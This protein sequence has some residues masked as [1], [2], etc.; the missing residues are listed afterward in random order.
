MIQFLLAV[1]QLLN[2]LIYAKGEGFGMADESI[3]AR[4]WRLRYTGRNWLY[5][6]KVIDFLFF[7]QDQH[8]KTAYISEQLKKQLP[9]EYRCKC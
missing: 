1:D 4:S 9:K 3:S 7:W 8:C 2:T 5:A 6:H